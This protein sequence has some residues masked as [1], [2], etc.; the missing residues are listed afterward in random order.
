VRTAGLGVRT[1]TVPWRARACQTVITLKRAKALA[2]LPRLKPVGFRASRHAILI[3]P[4]PAREETPRPEAASARQS[5]AVMVPSSNAAAEGTAAGGG[6]SLCPW[7]GRPC[8][9]S[10][11]LRKAAGTALS[12]VSAM[13]IGP[14]SVARRLDGE[15]RAARAVFAPSHALHGGCGDAGGVRRRAPGPGHPPARSAVM[16][17]RWLPERRPAAYCTRAVPAMPGW[18]R[19]CC[20]LLRGRPPHPAQSG[21]RP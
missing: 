17:S 1:P 11:L 13:P 9:A 20:D 3:A 21:G 8:S 19:Y 5:P 14:R 16:R 18:Y 7:Q 6:P 12:G 2:L 15:R 10:R 4:Q